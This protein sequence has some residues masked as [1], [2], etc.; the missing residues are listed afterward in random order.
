MSSNFDIIIRGGLV[1]DGMGTPGFQADI[2]LTGDTIAAIGDLKNATAGK[3]IDA[4]GKTVTPGFIDIHSHA[5]S[6]VLNFPAAE[7]AVGQGITTSVG[8]QC[9]FS[10][11]PA[12]DYWVSGTWDWNWWSKASPYKYS[13]AALLDLDIAR[14]YSR[15]VD[16]CDID[17]ATFGEWMERVDRVRPGTNI[18]PL[19]GHGTIRGVVMGRDHRRAATEEEVRKMKYWV[20]EAMDSGA[21]GFSNGLDYA[22]NAWS[23][24][25]ESCELVGAAAGRGGIFS[26]HWRRTGLRAVGGNPGLI[27]GLRE[28]IEIAKRTGCRIQI[29]HLNLGY[30]VSPEPTHKLAVCAAEETLALLDSAISEGTDLA[31]DVIPHHL[32]GG[33][34]RLKYV[35]SILSPWLWVAGNLEQFAEN[36]KAPD[37]RDEIRNYIMAGKFYSINPVTSP[38]WAA[39][40]LI[41]KSEVESYT[42]KT[43]ADI[44]GE[45]ST[46]PLDALF[47]V[48]MDDPYA[49]L[50]LG[51]PDTPDD[52]KRVFYKHPR[53]MAGTDTK[54]F[55]TAAEQTIPP[56]YVPNPNTYG[57]M[58][59]YIKR[60]GIGMLG[61][62]EG[63]RRITSLPA[64]TMGLRDRG[65]IVVGKK[66]DIVVMTPHLVCERSTDD[67]PR[68][69]PGGFDWVLVNGVPA[70]A[71]GKHTLSRSGK[72]LR[73]S[74][75]SGPC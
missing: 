41:A 51:K 37:Y 46:D 53:A 40:I 13:R 54:L 18:C 49:R 5:E 66:A 44:A 58:A 16:G 39:G 29:A 15:E 57:G 61:F 64:A 73:H 9:G 74:G 20:E 48:I 30:L 36:L 21:W 60:Y 3:T 11:A 4:K 63:I 10:P 52:V 7:S 34:L 19:V 55:D 71:D 72:V 75:V 35:A 8:G 6:T 43:I 23:T 12:K 65:E 42:G 68:Q 56:Y 22:P 33:I 1:V 31:F 69:Y 14:K 24:L 50:S 38:G 27:N 2:G 45:T 47:H 25:E 59:R 26:T 32:T 62:E 67:E 70:L 28:A 17:W